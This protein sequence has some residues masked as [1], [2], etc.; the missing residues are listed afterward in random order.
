MALAVYGILFAI[1]TGHPAL[2]SER[3]PVARAKFDQWIEAQH[4]TS[5]L[6]TTFTQERKLRTIRRPMV[7]KGRMWWD[8]A[9]GFRWELDDPP[10]LVLIE[11]AEGQVAEIRPTSKELKLRSNR[12]A[13]EEMHG[14]GFGFAKFFDADPA[15]W[16]DELELIH[17]VTDASRPEHIVVH[18]K[19]RRPKLA[20]AIWKMI[21]VADTLRGDMREFQLVFRDQSSIRLLFDPMK[22]NAVINPRLFEI[23]LEGYTVTRE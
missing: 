14:L 22:K 3:D 7:T 21:I 1:P 2:A 15:A 5:T 16:T 12:Q 9:A 18:L 19:F 11:D 17:C 10:K 4:A 13:Q 8:R 6:S 23:P 20:K